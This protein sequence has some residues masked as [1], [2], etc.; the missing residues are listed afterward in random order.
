M[1][2]TRIAHY[3][4]TAK[5][6]QG[7]MG[8]VYRAKDSKL[9][10]EVAIKVLPA[11]VSADAE[12]LARFEREAKTLAALN[13]PNIASIYGLEKEGA[14]QSL[15]L[16]L[17]DGEDLSVVLQRGPLSV[18]EAL[19]VALEIAKAL[20]LA[21]E[22]GIVHRDL[23]PGNIK[24]LGEGSVKVLDF[25]LSKA[26]VDE[27][28][29]Y[30][31]RDVTRDE[32]PTLTDVFT[33][34]GTI[35]GTAAY[36]PPEQARGKAIDKRADVWSFGCVLFECLA[37]KK[38]FGGE[39]TAE[40]LAAV[41]KGE[42]E[43]DNLPESIPPA[44]SLLLRRC[45]AKNRKR[46]LRDMSDIRIELE[47]AL[48]GSSSIVGE[49]LGNSTALASKSSWGTAHAV[50]VG[51]AVLLTAIVTAAMGGYF[52]SETQPSFERQA[53]HR[54]MEL[55]LP[56]ASHEYKRTR[57]LISPDGLKILFHREDGVYLHDL[58]KMSTR[59]LP[60]GE[61]SPKP[62]WS[63]DSREIGFFSEKRS[64]MFRLDLEA[65]EPLI[66]ANLP[67]EL[68]MNPWS[69]G[70]GAPGCPMGISY[71]AMASAE[72]VRVSGECP[73]VQGI[74]NCFWNRKKANSHFGCQ[75]PCLT[76]KA[77]SF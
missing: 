34:P 73:R 71:F 42:P 5:L 55:A 19:K 36:M 38:A 13:H 68:H 2:G 41:I 64:A 10:R 50:V 47:D 56:G 74:R 62:F 37:G 21:H 15:I 30:D 46:R 49:A 39:D 48:D 45:L 53:P 9:D 57:T 43:W 51:V 72:A 17:V 75:A 24:Y 69:K 77:S 6:G 26:L 76:G 12:R 58:T 25:G 18:T 28:E 70:G 33:Q 3:E 54:M 27:T 52:E 16:E 7:G 22:K 66:I 8:E 61:W 31:Q 63:P 20:E 14:S 65:S 60:V 23:K 32:S 67:D 40:T 29:L 35:L 44:V 4:I 11:V 59:L 1:V